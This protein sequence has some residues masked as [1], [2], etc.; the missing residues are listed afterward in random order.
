MRGSSRYGCACFHLVFCC[1]LRGF[2]HQ[3]RARK[4]MPAAASQHAMALHMFAAGL[5]PR[6][7][8]VAAVTI[9]QQAIRP[10]SPKTRRN[11]P[12]PEPPREKRARETKGK[13]ACQTLGK[14]LAL[15]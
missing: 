10:S 5:T 8:F 6:F 4:S 15:F 2:G 7:R 13:A 3:G 9:L 14:F 11:R 1:D 12:R